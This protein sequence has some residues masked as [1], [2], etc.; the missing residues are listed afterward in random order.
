MILGSIKVI[1]DC[2]DLTDMVERL[3]KM[4]NLAV[5]LLKKFPTIF[6][7]TNFRHEMNYRRSHHY[8]NDLEYW[9]NL[10]PAIANLQSFRHNP[11]Y[12]DIRIRIV[13]FLTY[14]LR[15]FIY[16]VPVNDL[17]YVLVSFLLY[18]FCC[19]REYF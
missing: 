5:V 13:H 7:V 10:I 19:I 17:M 14:I 1:F 18:T 4:D 12:Y 8:W 16:I 15:S 2:P 3:F 6:C 11:C 9:L